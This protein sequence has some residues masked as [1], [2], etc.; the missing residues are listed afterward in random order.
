ML[1]IKYIRDNLDE[2]R[3]GLLKM[4]PADKLDLEK[5]IKLDD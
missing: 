2:V 3:A 4:M 5:I 1:D